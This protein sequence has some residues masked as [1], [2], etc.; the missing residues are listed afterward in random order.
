MFLRSPHPNS[1]ELEHATLPRASYAE[2]SLE[3][4]RS[5][6]GFIRSESMDA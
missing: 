2:H 4:G 1:I 5:R 3:L 6:T